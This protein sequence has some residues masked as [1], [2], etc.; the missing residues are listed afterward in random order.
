MKELI[1]SFLISSNSTLT[2]CGSTRNLQTCKLAASLTPTHTYLR[3][4]ICLYP[5]MCLRMCTSSKKSLN[6]PFRCLASHPIGGRSSCSSISIGALMHL[7]DGLLMEAEG[8]VRPAAA[9]SAAEMVK[10]LLKRTIEKEKTNLPRTYVRVCGGEGPCKFASLQV[11]NFVNLQVC[12]LRLFFPSG[13]KY[14]SKWGNIFLQVGNKFSSSPGET[15]RNPAKPI[16][17]FG[18]R[19]IFAKASLLTLLP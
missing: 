5:C 7:L 9:I 12:K 3:A 11:Y 13:K 6:S 16:S 17:W 10:A 18:E 1:M 19:Y 4:R 8:V 2:T 14:F 15:Q